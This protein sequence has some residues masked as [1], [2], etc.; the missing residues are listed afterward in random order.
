M[1]NT[2]FF[3]KSQGIYLPKDSLTWTDLNTSPYATWDNYTTWY[4]NLV[5]T[6]TTVEFTPEIIDFGSSR[7]VLPLLTI[8]GLRDG[9]TDTAAY[10]IDGKPTI[11]I[12]GSTAANMSG[13]TTQLL[14][15]TTD[16][17]Y[18]P[19]IGAFRYYRF[20]ININSGSNTT[21]QGFTGFNIVLSTDPLEEV[22]EDFDT[23]TVDDGSSTTRRIT[24][25]N[26]YNA[27]TFVG[28]TPKATIRDTEE[29]VS[30][31]GGLYMAADYVATDNVGGSE[32]TLSS[33]S[34][35]TLPLAQL[36]ST[37]TSS[38]TIRLLA[39][40]TGDDIN[41]TVDVYVRGLP[42]AGIDTNGNLV[43]A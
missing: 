13:A 9:T 16:Y 28:I 6:S 10:Y 19:N 3:D 32:T 36:V 41:S 8:S 1:A 7:T 14:D 30:G 17:L 26:T 31:A 21:A 15:K 40:N 20:T 25:N 18:T 22:F 42:N 23:S 24:T 34:I 5:N 29:T 39:P 38:I 35:T 4:Q 2:G 11:L 37:T 33:V 43:K 27:I 12:E